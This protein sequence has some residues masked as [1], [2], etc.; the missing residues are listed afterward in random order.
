MYQLDFTIQTLAPIII[1]SKYGEINTINTEKFLPGTAI[2]GLLAWRY[3]KYIKNAKNSNNSIEDFYQLFL[4]GKITFTNAW[5][6]RKNEYDENVIYY[7]APVSFR[8]SKINEEEIYNII[9]TDDDFDEKT[10]AIDLFIS[11]EEKKQSLPTLE[12]HHHH[13]R[14]RFTGSPAES[15]LFTYEAISPNQI[16]QGILTGEE[17][18]LQKLIDTCGSQW[19][20]WM[21]RSRNSQYGK[22]GILLDSPVKVKPFPDIE[23]DEVVLTMLAHTLIYNKHGFST[24]CIKDLEQY[25]YGA[26]IKKAAIKN[27]FI[28]NFVSVW[29]F[30]KPS[31]TGFHAGS[32][33]LLNIKNTDRK[34]LVELQTAGLG[35]RT[36]E[37]FGQI[38]LENI[39]KNSD[40]DSMPFYFS[41]YT[42]ESL[43][44]KPEID[45]PDQAKSIIQNIVDKEINNK[46]SFL[47]SDELIKFSDNLPSGSLIA[48]IEQFLNFRKHN[49]AD[50]RD[51]IN[52]LKGIATEQ[53]ERCRS[54]DITLKTFLLKNHDTVK[55]EK[56][57]NREDMQTIRLICNEIDYNPQPK[58]DLLMHLYFE[59][60][61]SLMKKRIK[62]SKKEN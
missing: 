4:D 24:T 1:A 56:I 58:A 14:D 51:D 28:E 38:R 44:E 47:A 23:D 7:P 30:K 55:I 27:K 17:I 29:G 20:G 15:Q 59:R 37:G 19:T 13:E 3:L 32:S 9:F 57:L 16:F 53:L 52:E 25:L 49:M 41:H 46:V 35:E 26:K 18:H 33:F 22:V 34:K 36:H 21:G 45:L 54:N 40:S 61:L 31:E 50:F 12:F 6:T 48:R 5:F 2:L 43:L 60:F 39:L 42:A 8:K 11:N 10:Q 62:S